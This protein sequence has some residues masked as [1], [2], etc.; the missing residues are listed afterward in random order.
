[1]GI[2]LLIQLLFMYYSRAVVDVILLSLYYFIAAIKKRFLQVIV[3]TV[4]YL[5]FY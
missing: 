4:K 3:K 2:S 1:M 5:F